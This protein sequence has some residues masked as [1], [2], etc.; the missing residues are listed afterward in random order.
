MQV[1]IIDHMKNTRL[2]RLFTLTSNKPLNFSSFFP[3]AANQ[4]LLI[5][6]SLHFSV[7]ALGYTL[8]A[9]HEFDLNTSTEHR[10]PL[11]YNFIEDASDS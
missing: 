6:T 9:L 3:R 11:R 10:A 7:L 1:L 4:S 8:L 2:E 5:E